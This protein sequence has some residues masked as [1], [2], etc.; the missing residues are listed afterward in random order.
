MRKINIAGVISGLI[1]LYLAI[2]GGSW[3]VATGGAGGESFHAFISPFMFDVSILGNSLGVPLIEWLILASRIAFILAGLE[4]LVASLLI[5]KDWSKSF[6][7]LRILWTALIFVGS[8][9]VGITLV[10]NIT[11]IAIPLQG[12]AVLTYDIPGQAQSFIVEA[13]INTYFTPTFEVALVGSISA[14]LAKIL[15]G[16]VAKAAPTTPTT[17]D[18]SHGSNTHA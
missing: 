18:N 11:G 13:P 10:Q 8:I 5:H 7:R 6:I 15:H 9:Y 14:L 16:R 12:T 1:T 3:W 4:I 2:L 17:A